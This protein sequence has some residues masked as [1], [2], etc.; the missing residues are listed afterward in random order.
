M[1]FNIKVYHPIK[2]DFPREFYSK[3]YSF[4]TPDVVI[5]PD[6]NGNMTNDDIAEWLFHST[7]A[8]ASLLSHEMMKVV[9]AFKE[10]KSPALSVGDIIEIGDSKLFCAPVGFKG[11]K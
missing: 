2:S 8:P 3:N 1:K 7:N 11:V 10:A 6:L 4:E 5:E 9:E